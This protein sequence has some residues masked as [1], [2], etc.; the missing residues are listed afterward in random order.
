MVFIISEI[1][2]I[3]LDLSWYP[4]LFP[5][6]GFH[7]TKTLLFSMRSHSGPLLCLY[8]SIFSWWICPT[9][10]V[11]QEVVRRAQRVDVRRQ[12]SSIEQENN[13]KSHDNNN[14]SKVNSR[15]DNPETVFLAKYYQDG[16][17][18]IFKLFC[19]PI[20]PMW[21]LRI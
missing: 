13:N 11:R 3:I 19:I 10:V 6:C 8:S 2:N 9:F 5:I 12:C 7:T 21:P 1:I 4:W 20:V 15:E 17:K 16:I 14:N 18:C